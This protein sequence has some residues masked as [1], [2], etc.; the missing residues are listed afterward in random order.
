MHNINE[1]FED[2]ENKKK[3]VKRKEKKITR[4]PYCGRIIPQKPCRCFYNSS[5]VKIKTYEIKFKFMKSLGVFGEKPWHKWKVTFTANLNTYMHTYPLHAGS[6]PKVTLPEC[7]PT[8]LSLKVLLLL[9]GCNVFMLLR[10]L[11]CEPST[12][13]GYQ[14]FTEEKT[15]GKKVSSLAGGKRKEDEFY[16][17][18]PLLRIVSE[19]ECL[20]II[21]RKL[22]VVL[23]VRDKDKRMNYRPCSQIACKPAGEEKSCTWNTSIH[24]CGVFFIFNNT[25]DMKDVAQGGD[26]V[27]LTTSVLTQKM[28]NEYCGSNCP[29]MERNLQDLL[30]VL[31]E[32]K[33]GKGGEYFRLQEVKSKTKRMKSHRVV[34]TV[35]CSETEDDA[36]V[37][38]PLNSPSSPGWGKSKT[39][40]TLIKE[41]M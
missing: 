11:C 7:S 25:P 6:I 36:S 34:T 18:S 21:K 4:Y 19:Q 35:C 31:N 15:K 40:E 27:P 13:K 38:L 3:S 14:C 8:R 1:N 41:R 39:W 5:A 10:N 33:Y 29:M 20:L 17:F 24:K 26:S 37:D 32:F 2:E 9:Q 16:S 12:V 23:T 30:Y 28:V 22:A